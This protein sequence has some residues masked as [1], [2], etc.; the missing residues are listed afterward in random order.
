MKCAESIKY[1]PDFKKSP[2]KKKECKTTSLIIF[3]LLT[4]FRYIDLDKIYSWSFL[5]V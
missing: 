2:K 4:Y 5:V 3:L 1:T